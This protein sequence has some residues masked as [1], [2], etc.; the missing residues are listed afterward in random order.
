[1]LHKYVHQMLR[2]SLGVT[3]A[4]SPNSGSIIVL[5]DVPMDASSQY[6]LKSSQL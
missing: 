4:Y 2:A 1:M 5:I 6:K 3:T